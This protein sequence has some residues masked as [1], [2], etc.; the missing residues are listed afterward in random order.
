MQIATIGRFEH[1]NSC[2]IKTFQHKYESYL[3]ERSATVSA[4]AA[5]NSM[6]KKSETTDIL[7][8]IEVSDETVFVCINR[9]LS[10]EF[11]LLVDPD[12]RKDLS[13]YS[14]YKG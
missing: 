3:L 7:G 4:I 2:V 6:S 5:G 8:F 10:L 14:G 1:K 9:L 11:E 13:M 12:L